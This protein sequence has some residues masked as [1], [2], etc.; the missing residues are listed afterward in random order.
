LKWKKFFHS[1][2]GQVLLYSNNCISKVTKFYFKQIG[3]SRGPCKSDIYCTV[4]CSI[5]LIW[6][7]VL[8]ADFFRL[9]DLTHWLTADFS[10]HI[11]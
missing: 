8:A 9:P 10:F 5:Y 4:D 7:Q 1:K 2:K 3:V 11:I 6:T